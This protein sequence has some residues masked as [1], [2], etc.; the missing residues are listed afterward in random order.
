MVVSTLAV[1]AT[2]CRSC[3][4]F[5]RPSAAPTM[6]AIAYGSPGTY[7]SPGLPAGMYDDPLATPPIA[8]APACGPGPG[9]GCT[10]CG[11]T[12]PTL[13]GAQSYAPVAGN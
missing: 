8:S 6:P 12:V 13:A 1:G 2:G 7:G 11:N 4:W 3:N 9:P 5:N 10:S